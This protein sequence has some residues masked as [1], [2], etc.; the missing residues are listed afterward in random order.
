MQD[1]P[2]EKPEDRV[3][4]VVERNEL[5]VEHREPLSRLR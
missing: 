3:S 5:A 1:A 4:V 2:A